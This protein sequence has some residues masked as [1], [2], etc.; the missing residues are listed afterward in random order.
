MKTQQAK[1]I[2][3]NS[4]K[5][6]ISE[7]VETKMQRFSSVSFWVNRMENEGEGINC[8][9]SQVSQY[10]IQILPENFFHYLEVFDITCSV[11]LTKAKKRK[12]PQKAKGKKKTTKR[13]KKTLHYC[14]SMAKASQKGK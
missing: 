8:K 14:C 10:Q 2:L 7:Y 12:N 9:H 6:Y 4:R 1:K 5:K 3:N 13:Q 11:L